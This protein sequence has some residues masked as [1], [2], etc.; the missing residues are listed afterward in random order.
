MSEGIA[1]GARRQPEI[2]PVLVRDATKPAPRQLVRFAFYRV[3]PEWRRLEPARRAEQR[4][5]LEAIIFEHASRL[6]VR[7][8]TLVGTRGDADFMLW[9]VSDEAERLQALFAAINGTALAGYL[10][11]SHSYTSMTKRSIYVDAEHPNRGSGGDRLV[12]AP[13]SR[14][15]LFV[16]PFVKSRAWWSL[17]ATERQ[18]MM[19]EHIRVGHQFPS[20][21]INTTYSFGLDDQEFVVAFETDSAADFLDCVQSL[22]D[23]EASAY[24]ARDVPSFTCVRSEIAEVLESLG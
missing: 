11:C 7:T 10:V 14:R 2:G 21:K 15:F 16:Y 8:Y 20:V 13:G 18:R 5:E 9:A 23:T 24:T 4:R 19:E 12:L 1:T 22:R 6:L 3:M 17:P